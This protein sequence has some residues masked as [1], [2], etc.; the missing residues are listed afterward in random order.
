MQLGQPQPEFSNQSDRD[1]TSG[2]TLIQYEP[3]IP[4]YM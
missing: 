3:S 2:G 1:W 4:S